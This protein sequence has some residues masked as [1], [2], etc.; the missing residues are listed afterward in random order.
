M[1]GIIKGANVIGA[2][3][4]RV[5][6]RV[7]AY[8]VAVAVGERGSAQRDTAVLD[9]DPHPVERCAVID[10]AAGGLA[11]PVGPDHRN[12]CGRGLLGDPGR[13][14]A[15]AD[16][17]AI[18]FGER[19]AGGGVVQS[20]VQ[21][22]RDQRG[23]AP[24]RVPTTRWQRAVRRRRRP[25]RSRRA[26]CLR[27]HCGPAPADQRRDGRAMPGATGQ[28]RRGGR[29]WR[30]ALAVSAAAD[31]S[32]P[33]GAPVVPDVEMTTATSSAISSP[34]RK[35]VVR[36]SVW[37]GSS[38]GTGSIAELAPPRTDSSSGSSA[39]AAAATPTG[40]A[41]RAAMRA[42]RVSSGVSR[43]VERPALLG[44]PFPHAL[45]VLFP[46]QFV[47]ELGDEDAAMSMWSNSP[48][49]IRS[50]ATAFTSS[51]DSRRVSRA[52]SGTRSG[53]GTPSG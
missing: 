1:P 41:R 9:A 43:V 34:A 27:V 23:I 40:W 19:C 47:G 12:A 17:D 49:S 8:R 45:D 48:L 2:K 33:F 22:H 3:P 4:A 21:L 14:R 24:A 51:L 18:Q 35:A 39:R 6:E 11:H 16:Q 36:S 52:M 26:W 5:T 53:P 44:Q 31:S 7:G 37:R 20:L 29:G 50:C 38:A 25:P 13:H 42:L 46:W 15:T 32:A 30:S 28:A 10:A